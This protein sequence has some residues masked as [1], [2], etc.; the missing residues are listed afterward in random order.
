MQCDHP[1]LICKPHNELSNCLL[2]CELMFVATKPILQKVQLLLHVGHKKCVTLC[3]GLARLSLTCSTKLKS[4]DLEG[5]FI[6]TSNIIFFK[7]IINSVGFVR[8]QIIAHKLEVQAN[9]IPEQSY[10]D[11]KDLIFKAMCILSTRFEDV[12]L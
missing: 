5:Q 12:Q 9:S 10:I 6:H 11:I 8:L 7:N 3:N 2:G 4:G 1:A